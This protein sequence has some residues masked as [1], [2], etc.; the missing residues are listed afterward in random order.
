MVRRGSR[1]ENNE[2]GRHDIGRPL[3]GVFAIEE[4]TRLLK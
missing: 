4:A 2:S 3:R 1:S